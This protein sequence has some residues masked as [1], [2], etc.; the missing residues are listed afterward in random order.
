MVR[1]LRGNCCNTNSGKTP[2]GFKE[3]AAPAK[4]PEHNLRLGT[5]AMSPERRETDKRMRTR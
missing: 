2:T 5:G 3:D 4:P 1:R